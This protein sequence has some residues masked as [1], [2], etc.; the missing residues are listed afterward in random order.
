MVIHAVQNSAKEVSDRLIWILNQH[1]LDENLL[2]EAVQILIDC[3]SVEY[4]FK[5]Q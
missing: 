4:A 2:K 5:K 3:G 1:T